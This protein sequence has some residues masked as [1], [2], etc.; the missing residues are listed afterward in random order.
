MFCLGDA[1]NQ[2]SILIIFRMLTSKTVKIVQKS[3][4]KCI[5]MVSSISGI[6]YLLL[7]S[8]CN[9]TTVLRLVGGW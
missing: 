1:E 3:A 6:A 2:N 5:V 4:G 8:L 7:D 9:T